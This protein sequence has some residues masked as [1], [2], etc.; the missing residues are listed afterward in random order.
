MTSI[1]YA[2]EPYA[3]PPHGLEAYRGTVYLDDGTSLV[4]IFGSR[5]VADRECSAL[6]E[7]FN[8]PTTSIIVPRRWRRIGGDA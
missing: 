4:A 3:L 6:H 1:G 7:A 2:V 8:H 5:S